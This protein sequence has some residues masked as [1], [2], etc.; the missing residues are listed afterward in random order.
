MHIGIWLFEFENVCSWFS[1]FST[2]NLG[3]KIKLLKVTYF[4][5]G[6]TNQ[7]EFC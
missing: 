5:L 2:N 7:T 6:V 1:S 4:S 3:L